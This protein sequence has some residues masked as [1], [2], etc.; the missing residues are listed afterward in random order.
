[1]RFCCVGASGYVVNLVVF[2]LLLHGA[3]AHHILAALGS[4]AVSWSTN[5][6]FNKYW[7][8]KR[9]ELPA[10]LQALRY[11]AVS[12]VALG[13]GLVALEGLVRAGVDALPAQAIAI[14]L[15]VPVNFLLNRR[16]SFR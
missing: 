11:L 6:V 14:A 8:F 12:L 2:A 4:F 15:A 5:F 9:H 1:M 16:W 3:N 10:H 7:T 13:L